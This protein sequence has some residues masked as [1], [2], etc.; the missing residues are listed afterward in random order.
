MQAVAR[1]TAFSGSS[2][3][4]G[5]AAGGERRALSHEIGH[6]S[7]WRARISPTTASPEARRKPRA[8]RN[9]RTTSALR[10]SAET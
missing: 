6:S 5:N 2:R 9:E 3:T 4:S 8:A 1:S 10:A 7:C